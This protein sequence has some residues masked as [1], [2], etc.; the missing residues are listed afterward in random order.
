MQTQTLIFPIAT[1]PAQ[2]GIIVNRFSRLFPATMRRMDR[3]VDWTT[4]L[5]AT[6]LLEQSCTATERAFLIGPLRELAS[7][8]RHHELLECEPLVSSVAVHEMGRVLVALI[9]WGQEGRDDE[10][11]P[12]HLLNRLSRIREVA[13]LSS[14]PHGN[15]RAKNRNHD[16]AAVMGHIEAFMIEVRSLAQT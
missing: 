1:G 5:E 11:D 10:F 2:V 6:H 12:K 16:A 4:M 3:P 8:L 14:N 13:Q 9:H 15:P 7:L